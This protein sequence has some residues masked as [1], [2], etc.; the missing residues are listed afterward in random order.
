M[1]ADLGLPGFPAKD[2][3]YRFLSQFT[4]SKSESIQRQLQ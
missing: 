2:L 4:S 1:C 3:H